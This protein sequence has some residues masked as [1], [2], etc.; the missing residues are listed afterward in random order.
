MSLGSNI[1]RLRTGRGLS[2]GDLAESLQVSRQS[3]SKWETDGATP[4]LDKLLAL[5]DLF[6]VSLDVLVRGEIAEQAAAEVP[7][8]EK[9]RQKDAAT[10]SSTAKTVLIVILVILG[11]LLLPT[12]FMNPSWWPGLLLLTVLGAFGFALWHRRERSAAATQLVK[13]LLLASFILLPIMGL[14]VSLPDPP[15]YARAGELSGMTPQENTSLVCVRLDSHPQSVSY[16][17]QNNSNETVIWLTGS[18]RIEIKKDGKWYHLKELTAASFEPVSMTLLPGDAKLSTF[19]CESIYGK[20][21]RGEYRVLLQFHPD[22][23]PSQAYWIAKEFK[24]K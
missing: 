22:G 15:V 2:Q 18:R 3:I 16:A 6:G 21:S 4:D 17:F 14:S 8:G 5:C 7:T 12:V 11:L 10:G 23:R 9:A 13:I 24:I 19:Y 1:Y 20:L